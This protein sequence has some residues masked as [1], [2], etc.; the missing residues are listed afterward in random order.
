MVKKHVSVKE[1]QLDYRKIAGGFL[2]ELEVGQGIQQKNLN[3]YPIYRTRKVKT[4]LL[5]L[6]EALKAGILEIKET[7]NIKE[8]IVKNKSKD[9]KILLVEGETIKGGAQN[10]VI[11]T[12][13]II[14]PN[15]QENIS[16]SCVQ[17]QRWDNFSAGFVSSGYI[18]PKVHTG[19]SSS[20][21]KNLMQSYASSGGYGGELVAYSADQ[22]NLWSETS[23]LLKEA[24]SLDG[25]KDIHDAYKSKKEDID[26]WMEKFK[27]IFDRPIVG[28]V[29]EI[30][31]KFFADISDTIE[32]ASSILDQI[33]R[34][35]CL[36]AIASTEEKETSL[37]ED[38]IV[39]A[40][41]NFRKGE[42]I[43]GDS[44]N[45]IG[46][47]IRIENEGSLSNIFC[48]KGAV[49]H[50]VIVNKK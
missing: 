3:L 44:P 47:D 31:G 30:D 19:L 15:T 24:G 39:G 28:V 45:K 20:I 7:G 14:L 17:Q 23:S 26:K 49:I 46:K 6:K 22:D 32:F 9:K 38:R 21:H 5:S 4:D 42:L 25:T 36:E 1:R 13:I 35:Y 29:A 48:Y 8:V 37:D 18:T 12:T 43:I 50:W 40:L 41:E 16:T 10:R 11:N 33:V 2:D 27:P 34:S